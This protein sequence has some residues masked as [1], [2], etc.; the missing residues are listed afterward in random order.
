[1]R[2]DDGTVAATQAHEL[3]EGNAKAP[4]SVVV[5]ATLHAVC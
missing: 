4:H 3:V 2:I 5:D 1:V